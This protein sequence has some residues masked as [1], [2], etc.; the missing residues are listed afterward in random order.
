MLMHRFA[1][2]SLRAAVIAALLFVA[3]PP[4]AANG[5]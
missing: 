1:I 3:L 2:S 5:L 4:S